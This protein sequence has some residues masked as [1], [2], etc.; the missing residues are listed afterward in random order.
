[1]K[2]IAIP[3]KTPFEDDK[4]ATLSLSQAFEKIQFYSKQITHFLDTLGSISLSTPIVGIIQ[5]TLVKLHLPDKT[6]KQLIGIYKITM[7][8][9]DDRKLS[10]KEKKVIVRFLKTIETIWHQS[11]EKKENITVGKMRLHFAWTAHTKKHEEFFTKAFEISN[12]IVASSKIPHLKDAFYGDYIITSPGALGASGKYHPAVDNIYL[13]SN[14]FKNGLEYTISVI[15]HETSHRYYRKV[16]SDAEKEEWG[17]F[18]EETRLS[19]NSSSRSGLPQIGDSLYWKYGIILQDQKTL[20]TTMPGKDLIHK[21]DDS[22]YPTK[23]YFRYNNRKE[24]Y[25]TYQVLH[26]L[27]LFPTNY[28]QTNK[29]EFFCEIIPTYLMGKL[30][31]PLNTHFDEA[32]KKRFI[33]PHEH[34]II[35][36][37]KDEL[38]KTHS[39]LGKAVVEYYQSRAEYI[40]EARRATKE[41]VDL[42]MEYIQLT[43]E[44]EQ[45]HAKYPWIIPTELLTNLDKEYDALKLSIKPPPIPKR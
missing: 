17:L 39:H 38:D 35:P 10:E 8:S 12:K 31:E 24:D 37:K 15:I 22:S 19:L 16:L 40:Y 26:N 13:D 2:K 18:Y 23:Y 5:L 44:L 7:G 6:M 11:P 27:G 20:S 33:D 30:S 4:I 9:D 29:E 25:T 32:L 1:M 3:I 14:L 43:Q 21:I 34:S 45:N 36:I 41:Q 42:A 28:S